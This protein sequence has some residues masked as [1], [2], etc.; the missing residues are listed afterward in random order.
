MKP[1]IILLAWILVGTSPISSQ[2]PEW[3]ADDVAVLTT[4]SQSGGLS[5]NAGWI[6]FD[7][8][9]LVIDETIV[10]GKPRVA[11]I[12]R[13]YS[14]KPIR[15]GVRTFGSGEK[16]S[17]DHF[18]DVVWLTALESDFIAP[19]KRGDMADSTH[20]SSMVSGSVLEVQSGTTLQDSHHLVE[21]HHVNDRESGSLAVYVPDSGVLFAGDLVGS[22]R[23]PSPLP[24]EGWIRALK[25][26]EG[27]NPKIVVAGNGQVLGPEI[28]VETRSTLE[29][30]KERVF[31]ALGY[32]RNRKQVFDIVKPED[33]GAISEFAFG[34]IYDELVGLRPATT[35]ID[36]LGLQEGPSP[37]AVSPGW[38]R[39]TKIVVADLWPGRTGQLALVAPGVDVVVAG[40]PSE[41]AELGRDADAVLGW[42]TPQ[43]FNEA[44]NLR[45]VQLSSAGVER[46]LGIPGLNESDVVLSNAQR[47]F[48]PG[49]AE[50]VL[51]MVLMLSRRLNVALELQRKRRWDITPLTGATP[52]IGKGSELLEL[53]GRTLLVVGLG[54]IGTEVARVAN[55]IGMR[56]IATR[57]SSRHGPPFVEYVGLASE[58][59]DLVPEADVIVNSLPLTPTTEKLFGNE[60]FSRTKPTSFL[61]NI[62][63]GGTVDTEALMSALR[64]GRI[65]GAGLDVTDPEPLPENHDLW[66]MPN[67]IITPHLGGDGDGHMER[68]WLLFRENLRRFAKGEPLLSV[69]NKQ[70]GY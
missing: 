28:I 6:E 63:R 62:G 34:K 51:G 12:A 47:I 16:V 52:Y 46:Y 27:M 55:G 21:F 2:V 41:A 14:G 32:A 53:R 37:T 22:G 60:F 45:W 64:E 44:Q 18:A 50:H 61:I 3:V 65:L 1:A 40:N 9:V 24:I 67:V 59:L 15:F 68:M 43:I 29:K 70:R 19:K 48:G 58:L 10:D 66:G 25:R 33:F 26:F 35:F 7:D 57:G 8:Y 5:G 42:L 4:P 38:T 36:D 30:L 17:E 23:S 11:E 56:V 69:V 49:G 20:V 39:P 54:G 31:D 13:R